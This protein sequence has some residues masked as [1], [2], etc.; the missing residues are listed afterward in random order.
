MVVA[1]FSRTHIREVAGALLAAS[2]H[3]PAACAQMA[4]ADRLEAPGWWPTKSTPARKDYVGASTCLTCHTSYAKQAET[5]MARTA[6]RATDSEILG[7]KAQWRFLRGGHAYEIHTR[8]TERRYVV[9][10]GTRSAAVSL[11]WAIGAGTIGQTYLYESGGVFHESRVSYFAALDG[12]DFTPGRAPAPPPLTVDDAMGRPLKA[13][14]TQRCFGC[15]TTA[16][17]A[18]SGS[19]D[20]AGLVAGIS[21]EACHG[22]GR[23]HVASPSGSRG[24]PSILSPARLSPADSVD[25]CG[26]CHATFWDVELAGEKGF[27]ALRSQPYR[28]Q[29]SRCWN[30]GDARLTCIAC[31]DPHVPLERDPVAYDRRCLAC[32]V[33]AGAAPTTGHP[34][35]ACPS[36]RVRCVTC[37]MPK[38]EIPEMHHDF[39]DHRI[40]VVERAADG[41]PRP[42]APTPERP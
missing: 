30:R 14:E 35:R 8:G 31:H 18:H 39:T 13:S 23:Q 5:T 33:A 1:C 10:D 12:L 6:K 15:H 24:E 9:D 29:S 17:S 41:F 4:T 20:P 40:R 25:F 37:H 21:C 38:Y 7:A 3:A 34:G 11:G 2:L 32:H 27:A 28:L 19:F 16:S 42:P 26:A 22:P 36:G